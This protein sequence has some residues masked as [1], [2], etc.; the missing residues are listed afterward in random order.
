MSPQKA[1]QEQKAPALPDP[2]KMSGTQKAALFLVSLGVETSSRILRTMSDAEVQQ[3]SVEVARM[4][5]ATSDMVEIVLTEY[6]DLSEAKQRTAQGGED[7]AREMLK[8]ALGHERADEV[9]M[10]VE[11]EM[12]VSAFHLLQ[13]VETA[14]LTN[15]LQNE[16]PQT[17]ALIIA[18]LH[19]RKSADIISGL[20]EAQRNEIMYR[21]ATMGK[22]SPELLSDIEEVIRTQLGSVFGAELSST[23]GIEKVA[24]ILSTSSRSAEREILE[25]MRSRSEDVALAIK[26]LM[27]V[28][29]DLVHIHGRD[30]QR[31]LTEVDQRDLAL[32][33]KAASDEL[34]DKVMDNVSERVA[35]SIQEELELMGKVRIR[36][37]D[38]AQRRILDIAQQLEADEEIVLASHGEETLI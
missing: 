29:D 23:G 15:F 9:M 8:S 18:H 2:D 16:H 37:V 11:A 20:D 21:L 17:V 28:F 38:D 26:N 32:A 10:Q 12:E 6:R 14:Q 3:I 35:E 22:T 5:N 34:K 1:L 31:I 13:T 4:R 25:A 36:D 7:V 24:D 33:L 27:F 19:P 30:L